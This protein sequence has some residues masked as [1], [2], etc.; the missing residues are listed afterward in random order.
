MIQGKL[1]RERSPSD[2]ARRLFYTAFRLE[3][4]WDYVS[5]EIRAVEALRQDEVNRVLT[6]TLSGAQRRRLVIR[7]IGK[8]HPAA[9]PRG[10]TL[11]LPSKLPAAG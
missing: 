1:Q 4:N 8:G 10:Q 11:T 7:L 9:T 2:A 3:Q 5:E 6:H